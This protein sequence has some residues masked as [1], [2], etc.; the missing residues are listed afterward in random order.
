MTMII[1]C[2]AQGSNI[3]HRC[4]KRTLIISSAKF[5]ENCSG[6]TANIGLLSTKKDRM[7]VRYENRHMQRIG[8]ITT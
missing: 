4:N 7:D 6:N 1:V 8:L 5:T 2:Y 3:E